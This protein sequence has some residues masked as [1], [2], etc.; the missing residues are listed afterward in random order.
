MSIEIIKDRNKWDTFV[1]DNPHSLLFHKWD[2][3]KIAEKHSGSKL[4][5]YG[6]FNDKNE[7]L[8]GVLPLFFWRNK[9]IKF[10]SSKSLHSA[11]TNMGFL[12]DQKYY[13]LKQRSKESYLEEIVQ[14]IDEQ[15]KKI[16]PNYVSI[17]P[18]LGFSDIRPFIWRGYTVSAHYTYLIDLEKSLESLWNQFESSCR[19]EIR[20]GEKLHLSVEQ[21]KDVRLF[22]SMLNERYKEQGLALP[23]ISQEFFTKLTSTFPQNIKMYAV[24]HNAAVTNIRVT[25]EYNHRFV[26]WMGGVNLDR[27][28]H[29]G[30]YSTWELIKKAKAEGFKE[31][32]L[33]GANTKNI[34]LFKSKYNPSLKMYF[35]VH[36]NDIIGKAAIWAYKKFVKKEFSF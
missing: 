6:F 9:G 19:R 4:L 16:T 35:N 2:Y 27:H 8:M 24:N 20:S 3:L 10:L 23:L 12:L 31:F 30:E 28:I 18:G 22:Y 17:S 21:T 14:E 25:C 13:T 5:A 36:K 26:A 29:S 7:N 15:V 32:E 33:Q 34:C 1:D 11:I